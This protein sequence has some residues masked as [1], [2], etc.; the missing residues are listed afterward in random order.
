MGFALNMDLNM[1]KEHNCSLFLLDWQLITNVGFLL[2]KSILCACILLLPA[3]PQL[4]AKEL[5]LL[6]LF[7][8]KPWATHT[9]YGRG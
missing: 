1:T 5:H 6:G 9:E 3:W 4:E 8:I 2:L 7:S